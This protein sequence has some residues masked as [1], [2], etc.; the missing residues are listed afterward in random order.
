MKDTKVI[1]TLKGLEED[2]FVFDARF[3]HPLGFFAEA[4]AF[5]RKEPGVSIQDIAKC[6]KFQFDK[7]E[8]ESLVKE[9]H[10]TKLLVEEL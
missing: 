8:L 9:L 6:F 10:Q 2:T 4:V 3:K 5:T 7:A 1:D